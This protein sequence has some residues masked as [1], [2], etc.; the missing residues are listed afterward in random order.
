MCFAPESD[1]PMAGHALD[2]VWIFG[3]LAPLFFKWTYL[4]A[5]MELENIVSIV[6]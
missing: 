4:E 6:I 1:H 3:E 5:Q 2:L